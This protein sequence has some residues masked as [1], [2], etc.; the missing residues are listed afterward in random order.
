MGLH[1]RKISLGIYLEM[2]FARMVLGASHDV[3]PGCENGVDP[4][5]GRFPIYPEMFCPRLSSLEPKAGTNGTNGTNQDKRGP[6]GAFR[7]KFGNAPI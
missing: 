7:D 5:W 3:I 2:I 6:N 4:K 1:D